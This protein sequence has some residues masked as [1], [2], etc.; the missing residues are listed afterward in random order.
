MPNYSWAVY[1]MKNFAFIIEA[2]RYR[3]QVQERVVEYIVVHY[4]LNIC[5]CIN[6]LSLAIRIASQYNYIVKKFY[7]SACSLH[8]MV[9]IS[10]QPKF[11]HV[12]EDVNGLLLIAYQIHFM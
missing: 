11:A 4:K 10:V 9:Q 6:R 8:I 3:R 1:L 2:R 7:R 5:T 12:F